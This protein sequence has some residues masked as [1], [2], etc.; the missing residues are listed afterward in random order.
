VLPLVLLN[1]VE[2]EE[3][4]MRVVGLDIHRSFAEAAMID[5][6]GVR[7]LGRI[8]LV[9]ERVIAFA[10]RLGKSAEVVVE[11][12]GNTMAVVKLMA[13]HVKRMV[14]ANPLQVRAIAHAKVKTDKIDAAVLAK[15]YAAGFLPE[16]WQ[17]DEATEQLRRQIAR[18]ATIVQSRTRVKNRIQSVLHANL[19]LP[20]KGDLFSGKGRKWL[21]AQ[22][23]DE[24]Q[25]ST[26]NGWLAELDRLAADLAE[27]DRGVAQSGLGD[28]RVRRLMT[29]T[30]INLTVAVGL[31][32]AI[33]DVTR[34]ASAEKLVSYFGLN[35]R[36]RQSGDGRAHHGRIT[37][38]GRSLARGLLVEAAW[39][40]AATAGPL[41][42][43]FVRIKARRGQQIA[44]V[45]TARKIAVL[46]WHLLTNNEDY[47]FGRPALHQ[48]KLRQMEIK[49]GLPSKRGGNTPG[50]ARDY[51]IKS[52]RDTERAFVAQAEAAYVRFIA[53]WSERPKKKPA[54]PKQRGERAPQMRSDS[55]GG[56]AGIPSSSPLLATRSPARPKA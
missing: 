24:D 40:A 47:A 38:Q 21:A 46:V 23:L 7:Q 18:R 35:P 28:E 26:I 12:T 2:I 52:M 8:D 11:A 56:A 31:M 9:R 4:D 6:G 10:K 39:A 30:G 55:Q 27:V 51:N 53:A 13:P 16:V 22:P 3:Q 25:R 41:H 14:I 50:R 48:A 42:A 19:I 1:E 54:D 32:A 29:I 5:E 45:A 17:P 36:V 15:L 44:V 20:Y 49:A 43:F 33:G 34:F 37:K